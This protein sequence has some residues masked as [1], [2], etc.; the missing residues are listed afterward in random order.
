[1]ATAT[2]RGG[3]YADLS[4]QVKQAGLLDRRNHADL[5]WMGLYATLMAA[6]WVAVFVIGSSWYQLLIAAALAVISVQ[7]AFVGH[8]VGHRQSKR[9]KSANDIVGVVT[10]NLLLGMSYSWWV[11]KHNRHHARPNQI[12]HDPDIGTGIFA[13]T[14]GQARTSRG[15]RRTIARHQALLFFP[16]LLLEALHLHIASI[17]FLSLR[18][19][20]H[21]TTESLLLG[22]HAAAYLGVL[23]WVLSPLQAVLFIVVHQGLLG[24]LL[25]S[26]FAPNHKGMPILAEE[27]ESDFLRR[28]VLTARNV[29]GGMVIDF[30]L[31]GLNYQIE[32]HL[33]PTMPRRN[34][35]RSQPLVRAFCELHDLTYEERS[36][37]GSYVDVLRYLRAVGAP[38]RP[39]TLAPA[40]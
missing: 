7:L 13:W 25:G 8:D 30:A 36:L 15:G 2:T 21:R 20:G 39:A 24:L 19:R 22:L 38:I 40:P 3:G 33:F 31:G 16:M 6:G 18:S 37:L 29:R 17:R 14:S 10:V 12:G 4:R 32:H 5:A 11:D 26:A 28:Q 27:D 1:M 35:R 34:L 9:T 23:F